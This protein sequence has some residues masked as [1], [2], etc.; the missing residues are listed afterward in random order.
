MATKQAYFDM[1]LELL[2]EQGYSALKQATLCKR[3]G[4]T[5][6]AFYRCFDNWRDF[7]SQLLAHWHTD[8]TRQLVETIRRTD[9][10]AARL[11]ALLQ[12]ALSLPHGAEAAIRVWS[13]IDPQIHAVQASVDAQRVQAVLDLSGSLFPNEDEALRHA[14]WGLYLLVGYH[15]TSTEPDEF[16]SLDHLLRKLLSEMLHAHGD[17]TQEANTGRTGQG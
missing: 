3:V 12:F 1:A 15:F 13:K 2:A 14:Q 7:T 6:G 5:T 17:C 4:V 9:D 16:R 10:P 8:R 11:N